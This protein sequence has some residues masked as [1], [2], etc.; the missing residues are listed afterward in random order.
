MDTNRKDQSNAALEA[1]NAKLAAG[2]KGP[3]TSVKQTADITRQTADAASEAG[4]DEAGA[5]TEIGVEDE[6]SYVVAE[7]SVNPELAGASGLFGGLAAAGMG[8]LGA[9]AAGLAALGL[10]AGSDGDD[11]GGGTGS[12]TGTGTGTGTGSGTGSDTGSDT[13]TGPGTGEGNTV[14]TGVVGAG[15]AADNGL[16]NVPGVGEPLGG[17]VTTVIGQIEQNSGALTSQDPSGTIGPGLEALIGNP[18][19]NADANGNVIA[20]DQNYGIIGALAEGGAPGEAATPFAAI[21]DG[22]AG[23][24]ASA[25]PGGADVQ[26]ALLDALGESAS[27]PRPASVSQDL[28]IETLTG[29]VSAITSAADALP[30]GPLPTP[31]AI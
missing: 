5:A 9:A 18:N 7:G 28:P 27:S 14:Q 10:L 13:G 2:N 15:E 24:D 17:A 22:I 12:D 31:P 6:I 20:P 19:A 16:S 29:A 8:P 25:L 30:T 1:A 11:N 4:A 26:E 3:V 23:Q 21:R